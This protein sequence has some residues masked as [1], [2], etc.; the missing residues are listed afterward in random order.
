VPPDLLLRKHEIAIHDDLEYPARRFDE[1]N[2]GVGVCFFD[3]GRQTGGPRL[4]AS[5]A[6]VFDGDLHSPS[7]AKGRVSGS[8]TIL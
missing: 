6:A 2:F 8:G 3:L 5:D 7:V 4:V 1:L